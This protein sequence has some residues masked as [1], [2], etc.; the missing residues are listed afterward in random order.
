[1]T[2][3]ELKKFIKEN[4]LKDD[5]KIFV[6]DENDLDNKKRLEIQELVDYDN[7]LMIYP[8]LRKVETI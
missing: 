1:M 7:E 6:V 5:C 8:L 3:A 2:I 4:E